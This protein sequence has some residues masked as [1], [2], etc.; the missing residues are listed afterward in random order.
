MKK[1]NLPVSGEDILER[2]KKQPG[3]AD[4]MEILKYA[5]TVTPYLNTYNQF[6]YLTSQPNIVIKNSD[7]AAVNL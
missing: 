1:K 7:R 5:D 4:L 3:V 2:A 6:L